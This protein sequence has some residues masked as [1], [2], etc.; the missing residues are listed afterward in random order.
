[1]KISNKS[2]L[3][4]NFVRVDKKIHEN[5]KIGLMKISQQSYF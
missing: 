1:M 2:N 4:P 5:Y 3:H